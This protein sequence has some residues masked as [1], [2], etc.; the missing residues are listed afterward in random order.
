MRK[1]K[2]GVNAPG[3]SRGFLF[4][5]NFLNLGKN[6]MALTDNFG[7]YFSFLGI[8]RGNKDK[9]LK[10]FAEDKP[11]KRAI[12]P[13]TGRSSVP[14]FNTFGP[15]MKLTEVM[16]DFAVEWFTTLENLAAYNHDVGYAL[17]NI[18]Q[19]ANTDHE[20][21]FRDDISDELKKQLLSEIWEAE[22]DWYNF[23]EGMRSFK[24]D[25]IAQ[26][27]IN[28]AISI[29]IIPDIINKDIYQIV[30]IP[31]K[32]IRFVYDRTTD[33]YHPYQAINIPHLANKTFNGLVKLN[34]ITYKYVAWRRLF[35]GPYPT[36]P[37]LAAI[38]GL[39]IQ[40]DMIKSFAQIMKKLGM[41]GFL[42]AKVE[43][44]EQQAGEEETA[45]WAR[46]VTYLEDV[47]Y[48][49]LNKNL[50]NGVV[51]G[52]KDSHEF[53][54]QGNR[55]NVNG[56]DGL[57]K[58][59]ELIVFAGLKQD[60][61]MLGR[62]YSTTETFGRVI[63]A[64][65]LNQVKDWQKM[66][67]TIF[68]EIYQMFLLVKGYDPE[69]IT[70][71]KSDPPM[72]IDRGKEEE[73][74]SKKISN[75]KEKRNMG[76]IN[77]Q[78]AANEL[79]YDEPAEEEWQSMY[80][81]LDPNSDKSDPKSGKSDTQTPE[82]EPKSDEERKRLIRHYEKV[83]HKELPEYEY[84][85][86]E[87]HG[88]DTFDFVSPSDFGERKINGFVNKY[89]A[90]SVSNYR[91]GLTKVS[92]M[93]TK[94]FKNYDESTPLDRI[95]DDVYLTILRNWDEQFIQKQTTISQ[96]NLDKIYSHFRQDRSIFGN[97]TS[98]SKQTGQFAEGDPIPEAV[99]DLLDFRTIDYLS[100]SDA[101]Y[102]GKF[103]TDESTKKKIKA[104]LEEKYISGDLPLGAEPKIL[105]KFQD[106]FEKLLNLETW[107]IRRVIDTSVNNARN[108]GNVL[109]MK[110]AQIEKYEII[111]IVDN[112]TCDW[113]AHMD[114]MEFA[115]KNAVS[116]IQ[117]KV[118]VG[119]DNVS[120]IS[121]FATSIPIEDF[122]ELDAAEIE[123]KNITT[124][125]YHPS[126]RGRVV[127][128]I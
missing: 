122:Q 99:F 69:L 38:E 70:D 61:N 108:D 62:N 118:D 86:H 59:V 72:V 22:D 102:L 74:E 18:V 44:P 12:P 23:S 41:L 80:P 98:F 125:S 47:V 51:A 8:G 1:G 6:D 54:L 81:G 26:G 35:E 37:F 75:V 17:D 65:M 101:L 40:R 4:A 67:D 71:V 127:A 48:P 50:S 104:Y 105:N 29:E 36:P 24:S 16:P 121:P 109:Y 9:D 31:P 34:T 123:G 60:P 126:C 7:K 78:D 103:I 39:F 73:A 95:N 124:P 21:V 85:T 111:E 107:K 113:C 42:S 84:E 97:K 63:L 58:I 56:A 92:K 30:R 66:S 94:L 55:M 5:P 13:T 15:S 76:I 46:C 120:R 19:L 43:P 28:G 14:Q 115:I 110:Q 53:E 77:Q 68:K 100:E 112:L 32:Y 91:R 33:R 119:P 64:K 116:K 27:V 45:Y 52:F 79:G 93:I 3:E 2:E 11:K 117:N 106:E 57:M 90:E 114:G 89:F 88:V 49:Q 20:I 10:K 25:I 83:L 128:V 87:C 82:N 96:N